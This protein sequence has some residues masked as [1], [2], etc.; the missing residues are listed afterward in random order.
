MTFLHTYS[1][2]ARDPSNGNLGVAV[3]THWFA[4]GALCPWI[5]AGVGAVAT[6]SMVEVR[7]GPKC[8]DMLRQG[9]TPQ[10]A[11]NKLLAPDQGRDLRQV[12]VI[13][14][15]GQIATHTG[16][17]CIQE[18]GHIIGDGYSVQ[19]NM[20]LNNSV[21]PAMAEAFETA[22]GSLAERMLAALKAGQKAGG[23]MRGMQSA[24][25]LVADG[26]KTDEPWKHVKLDIRVDDHAAPLQELERLLKIQTAYAFM[27]EGDELLS[28]G[29]MDTA[30]E[31][32][33]KAVDLAPGN[34]EIPFWYAVTLANSG[35]IKRA[36]PVFE[37]IF[38][39]SPNWYELVRRLPASGLL[40]DD[41]LMIK[42]ISSL[43]K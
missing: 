34:E 26:E 27:N 36:L 15:A 4:V 41:P 33:Q 25:M 21:W 37:E 29:E 40:K 2:I 43:M 38:R 32:Y 6:Q 24:A 42:Q 5:E 23:D 13:N 8:L 12:A 9:E 39:K 16:S 19:A 3:Q 1:I 14:H 22:F 30:R 17:R 35:K 18:A 28:K 20:M 10:K 7:Y 31:A 11:L